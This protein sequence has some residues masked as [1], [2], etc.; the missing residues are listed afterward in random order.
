MM[1]WNSLP[2]PSLTLALPTCGTTMQE[3][4]AAAAAVVMNRVIFTR[5]TGH[6]HVARCLGRS[7]DREDPV[8]EA[9]PEQDP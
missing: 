3:Y 2:I 8:A 9:R 5:E 1:A 7:A 6:T 4:S